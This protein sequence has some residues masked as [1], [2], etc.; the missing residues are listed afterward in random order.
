MLDRKT[1]R[2][3]SLAPLTL[4]MLLKR[5]LNSRA[6]LSAAAASAASRSMAASLSAARAA[7]SDV[8]PDPDPEPPPAVSMLPGG[9]PIDL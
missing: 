6:T 7:S 8:C 9:D 3:K 4:G 5:P 2:Y 1:V